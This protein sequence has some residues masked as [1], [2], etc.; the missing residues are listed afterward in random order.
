MFTDLLAEQLKVP[1]R[2]RDLLRWAAILHDIGKLRVPAD[3]AEQARQADRGRSGSCCKAHPAH[4]AEIAAGLLPWLGEWADVIVEHHERYDGTGL[5]DR[6]GRSADQP[7][8]PDRLGRRRLRRHDRGPRLQAPGLAGRG[9]PRAG[10]VLRHPVR[11]ARRPRDGGR[12]R[13]PAAPRPGRCSPGSPTSRWWPQRRA[14]QRPWRGWSGASALATGAVAAGP[15]ALG[16]PTDL[17]PERRGARPP[18]RARTRLGRTARPRSPA[19][20][21]Q[22][23]GRR[24]PVRSG[25]GS[26][27]P[28]GRIPRPTPV[29]SAAAA[30]PA[31]A[32]RTRRPATATPRPRP[33]ARRRHPS[34]GSPTTAPTPKSTPTPTSPTGTLTGHGQRRGHR[35]GRHRR[36][37]APGPGRHRHRHGRHRAPGPS[38]P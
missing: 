38:A 11:P 3:A 6:S 31:P 24:R 7:R 34:S 19:R 9:A 25:I 30:T 13:A 20:R 36:R 26:G 27:Q 1:R 5:P 35:P 23:V 10:P 15:A 21:P 18:P 17:P 2:D 28:R 32:A 16:L 37:R 8:R 22:R 29:P 12:R 14:R 33:A 4:G